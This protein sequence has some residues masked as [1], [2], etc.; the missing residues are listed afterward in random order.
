[1]H[2]DNRAGSDSC[3]ADI[4]STFTRSVV[5]GFLKAANVSLSTSMSFPG[6]PSSGLG[7]GVGGGG[8]NAGMSAQEQNMVK[9]VSLYNV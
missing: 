9:T 1:M 3:E 4:N 6:L 7:S 8:D 2:R 5:D